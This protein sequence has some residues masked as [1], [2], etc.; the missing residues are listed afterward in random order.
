MTFNTHKSQSHSNKPQTQHWP[1]N[2]MTMYRHKQ[3][4]QIHLIS[5]H[6]IFSFPLPAHPHPASSHILTCHACHKLTMNAAGLLRHSESSVSNTTLHKHKSMYLADR[7][8]RHGSR[9]RTQGVWDTPW[10]TVAWYYCALHSVVIAVSPSLSYLTLLYLA[11]SCYSL[12]ANLC[13]TGRPYIREMQ[14]IRSFPLHL[15]CPNVCAWAC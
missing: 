5:Q 3:T 15:L 2:Q 10:V 9:W 6:F 12:P 1:T 11:L 8:A 13:Q 4:Q 14:K 7:N